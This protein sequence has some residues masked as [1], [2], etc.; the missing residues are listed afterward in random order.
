MKGDKQRVNNYRPLTLLPI[1]GEIFER[2]NL[3]FFVSIS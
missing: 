1:C 3:Q 2:L